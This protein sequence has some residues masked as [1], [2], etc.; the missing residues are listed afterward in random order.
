M[1]SATKFICME[2]LNRREVMPWK[3][4]WQRVA[5][6]GVQS[7]V[8]RAERL[9]HEGQ[10]HV[11]LPVANIYWSVFASAGNVVEDVADPHQASQRHQRTAS[12]ELQA[13]RSCNVVNPWISCK[14][15]SNDINI[16]HVITSSINIP[17]GISSST[18]SMKSMALSKLAF[19]SR[20]FS[21]SLIGSRKCM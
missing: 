9:E 10:V 14:R 4:R 5:A 20:D 21:P 2:S 17:L 3:F 13:P 16:Q 19:C 8:S 18:G 12:L 11:L 1:A 7:T 6:W 15:C